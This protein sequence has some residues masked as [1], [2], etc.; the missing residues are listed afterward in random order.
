MILT[1][2]TPLSNGTRPNPRTMIQINH[3]S[4]TTTRTTPLTF[5]PNFA[6][7]IV[8]LSGSSL[9][10]LVKPLRSYWSCIMVQQI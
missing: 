2:T 1:W 8:T 3:S 5:G 9:I 6:M 4:P 10:T 7:N